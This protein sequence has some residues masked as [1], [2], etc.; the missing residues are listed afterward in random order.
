MCFFMSPKTLETPHLRNMFDLCGA[1]ALCRGSGCGP[2]S[3]L[4]LGKP[5]PWG[6]IP[7]LGFLCQKDSWL[8]GGRNGSLF[9]HWIC[10]YRLMKKL[11]ERVVH[12][13]WLISSWASLLPLWANM[14][15][16]TH[17]SAIDMLF[18]LFSETIADVFDDNNM[19]RIILLMV[20]KSQGQPPG[21]Y[22]LRLNPVILHINWWSLDFW[23]INSIIN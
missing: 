19:T 21:M 17:M 22:K 8:I 3:N 11:K 1:A 4:P 9:S 5:S 20:R 6:E 16:N 13:F 12:Q 15:E 10:W 7:A 2:H 14:Y 18:F 23:T